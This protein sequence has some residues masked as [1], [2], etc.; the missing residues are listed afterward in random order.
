[1]SDGA[2]PKLWKKSFLIP[3]YKNGG[4][5]DVQNYRPVARLSCIPKIFESIVTEVVVFNVKSIICPEQHGFVRAVD[6]QQQIYLV[7][8]HIAL[9]NTML[10]H[11]CIVSSQLLAKSLTSNFS[12]YC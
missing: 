10:G 12:K 6:P 11:R 1:M 5:N 9:K 4:K 3:L 8:F 7:S 2:F